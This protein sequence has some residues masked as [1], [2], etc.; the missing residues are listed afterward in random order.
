MG[1]NM[2]DEKQVKGL[3]E[4]AKD[5]FL[6]EA[7]HLRAE[8]P[9]LYDLEE[10]FAR[11]KSNRSFRTLFLVL[12]FVIAALGVTLALTLFLQNQSRKVPVDISDFQ[13][14]NLKDLLSSAVNNENELDKANRAL[15]DMQ[16]E[17][18]TKS[19]ALSSD[20]AGQI[21][22]VNAQGMSAA[23]TAAA[24]QKLQ[25]Q[26]TAALDGLRAQYAPELQA[27]QA[28]VAA[29]QKKVDS[30]NQAQST[31]PASKRRCSTISSD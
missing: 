11:T 2:D 19:D 5:V 28:D 17:L 29:A 18:A 24:V 21:A 22:V 9:K 27:R 1:R 7:D 25:A 14:V 8:K 20:Y 16:Q 31:Q 12:G 6:Q 13:D 3:S 10:E 15:T 23:S 4:V 26:E 30:S